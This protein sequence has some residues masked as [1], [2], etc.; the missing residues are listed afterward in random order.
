MFLKSHVRYL[1]TIAQHLQTAYTTSIS[2]RPCTGKL[3]LEVITV[4]L[5][6]NPTCLTPSIYITKTRKTKK[7]LQYHLHMYT[8]GKRSRGLALGPE[9]TTGD[10]GGCTKGLP[11]EGGATPVAGA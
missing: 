8:R 6:R 3:L 10:A 2:I 4:N 1:R 5:P 7:K 11:A 9:E